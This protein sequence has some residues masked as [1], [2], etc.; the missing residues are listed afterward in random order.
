[1]EVESTPILPPFALLRTTDSGAYLERGSNDVKPSG[2][3]VKTFQ[4]RTILSDN[5]LV[6]IPGYAAFHLIQGNAACDHRPS[7]IGQ[8]NEH[9]RHLQNGWSPTILVKVNHHHPDGYIFEFGRGK[10]C[11]QGNESF[12]SIAGHQRVYPCTQKPIFV[13]L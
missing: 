9:L 4:L 5:T 6:K 12:A 8:Y 7:G 2:R 10:W 3:L 11:H 1:M 13:L